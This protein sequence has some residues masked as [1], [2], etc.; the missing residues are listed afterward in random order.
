MIV[1]ITNPGAGT[2]RDQ[3]KARLIREAF[4]ALGATVEVR[5]V[6]GENLT[7]AARLAVDDGAR[8]VVAAGG[9]GTVNAVASGLAGST[10]PLGVL[11]M[12]TLN[13]FAKDAGI[14]VELSDA[15]AL[16]V[17]GSA[18]RIDVGT[19]NDRLFLNNSSIGV[20][21][22]MVR[23][24]EA[25][26]SR[27][28]RSKWWAMVRAAIATFKRFPT[29]HVRLTVKEQAVHLET[30]GVL[31][32][33][34]IYALN[35]RMLGTRERLDAGVLGLYAVHAQTR[36][37]AVKLALSALVSRIEDHDLFDVL[38][39]EELTLSLSPAACDVSLDG[40][41]VKLHAP[42]HYQIQKQALL[43]ITPPV[44]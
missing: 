44:P 24:R 20:Y 42:L 31:V 7:A 19:V 32:A 9:D 25:Q 28:N 27:F 2:S 10:T 38:H 29:F 1:V 37:S 23:D 39:T 22:L 8:V 15:V 18:R 3:D 43:V 4:A 35:M 21:P 36:W 41:V 13:H 26:Q 11:P 14:P 12:G 33:N 40:E 34:N 17:T 16:I 5:E 30:P 6:A